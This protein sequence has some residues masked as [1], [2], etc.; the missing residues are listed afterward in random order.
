[1]YYFLKY[2]LSILL[3]TLSLNCLADNKYDGTIYYENDTVSV[4]FYI[5]FRVF[6]GKINFSSIQKKIN[7]FDDE[8]NLKSLSADEAIAYSFNYKGEDIR[9]ISHTYA[10]ADQSKLGAYSYSIFFKLE[11]KENLTVYSQENET[12]IPFIGHN[13][14]SIFGFAVVNQKYFFEKSNGSFIRADKYKFKK[15]ISNFF[16]DCE[17]LANKIRQKIFTNKE[18][19]EIAEYYNNNCI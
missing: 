17:V 11:L 9:M 12:F 1:M 8:N 10:T 6:S 3:I 19:F 4:K 13:I 18:I 16:S 14:L 2:F 5:P 15:D 7:Y